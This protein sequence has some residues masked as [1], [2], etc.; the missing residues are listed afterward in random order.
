MCH[1]A[2]LELTYFPQSP[3]FT[4]YQENCP[5]SDRL[6]V[7]Y[8]QQTHRHTGAP[9]LETFRTPST[10]KGKSRN[11]VLKDVDVTVLQCSQSNPQALGEN[12]RNQK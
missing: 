11:A 5:N 7:T 8:I 3:E 2:V 1:T 10:F 6:T 4:V 12:G 9:L